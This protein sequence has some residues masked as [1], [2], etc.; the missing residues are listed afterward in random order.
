MLVTTLNHHHDPTWYHDIL[1]NSLN[2]IFN[3]S[4]IYSLAGSPNQ[5]IHTSFWGLE[6]EGLLATWIPG[7]PNTKLCLLVV[8]NPLYGSSQR[9]FFV[10]SWTSRVDDI[11][12]ID[13][14]GFFKIHLPSLQLSA[15]RS[16]TAS[17]PCF[18]DD[19]LLKFTNSSLKSYRAPIGKDRLPK[20]HGSAM[21]NFVGGKPKWISLLEGSSKNHSKFPFFHHHGPVKNGCISNRIVPFQALLH[22]PLNHG[23]KS[24]NHRH[25]LL[26]TILKVQSE[27]K[28]GTVSKRLFGWLE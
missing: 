19:T 4:N 1:S 15:K 10:W 9:L 23:R 25:F 6:K 14:H 5:D 20:H 2:Q 27:L 13:G 11:C 8:G 22:F 24:T 3:P 21:L 7:G 16:Q 17:T 18:V 12:K 26:G 28:C